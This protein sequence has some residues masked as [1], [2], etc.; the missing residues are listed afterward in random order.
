VEKGMILDEIGDAGELQ[1]LR[2]QEYTRKTAL[3]LA[4]G[5]IPRTNEK[6]AKDCQRSVKMS[7]RYVP[8]K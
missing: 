7:Q 2:Y 4:A 5:T 8:V 3:L 1:P 6:M